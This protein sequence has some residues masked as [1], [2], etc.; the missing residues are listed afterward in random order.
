M[1]LILTEEG[2]YGTKQEHRTATEHFEQSIT[3]VL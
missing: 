3:D 2:L 1:Q